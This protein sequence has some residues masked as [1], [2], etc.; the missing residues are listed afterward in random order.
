MLGYIIHKNYFTNFEVF[1]C[2][3]GRML[4]FWRIS[5]WLNLRNYININKKWIIFYL[6]VENPLFRHTS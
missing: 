5:K 4:V 2:N 1:N 6:C 3:I